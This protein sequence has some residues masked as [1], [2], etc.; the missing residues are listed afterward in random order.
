LDEDEILR[1]T[2]VY[3]GSWWSDYDSTRRESYDNSWVTL[4]RYGD[5]KFTRDNIRLTAGIDWKMSSILRLIGGLSLDNLNIEQSATEPLTG[6]KYS[7]REMEGYEWIDYESLEII[8]EDIKEF[9]WKQ[10]RKVTTF[11]IP[12]GAVISPSKYFEFQIGLTKV[13]QRINIDES[14]DVVVYKDKRT[15]VRDGIT[16]IVDETEYVDGHKLPSIKDFINEFEFNFGA[17]IKKDDKFG[18]TAVLTESLFDPR[19]LKIGAFIS[20]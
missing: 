2:N 8:Q 16:T 17:T 14:Y 6:S 10:S 3:M 9:V 1:N 11:A 4:R 18:V 20:W 13:M 15:E 5:G 19:S 12:I 7:L